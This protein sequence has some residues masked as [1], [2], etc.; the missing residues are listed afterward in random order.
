MTRV[1]ECVEALNHVPE[2]KLV[3]LVHAR[4]P[5]APVEP[6]PVLRAGSELR[7]L[8]LGE[9]QASSHLANEV[10]PDGSLRRALLDPPELGVVGRGQEE[11]GHPTRT[12]EPVRIGRGRLRLAD[13]VGQV[14]EGE[15]DGDGRDDLPE[16]GDRVPVDVLLHQ[17]QVELR[18]ELRSP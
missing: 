12:G 11:L 2:L 3:T 18:S 17:A 13:L 4:A 10:L 6:E 1:G 8:V 5:L 7:G 16:G 14:D 15:D 9:L